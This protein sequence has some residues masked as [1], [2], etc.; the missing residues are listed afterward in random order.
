MVMQ[1]IIVFFHRN[2]VL[3]ALLTH[4]KYASKSKFSIEWTEEFIQTLKDLLETADPM[5]LSADWEASER[6]DRYTAQYSFF[7]AIPDFCFARVIF[8]IQYGTFC[9]FSKPRKAK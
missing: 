3:K 8:L 1:F 4:S 9:H 7:S 6:R 5:W 2:K